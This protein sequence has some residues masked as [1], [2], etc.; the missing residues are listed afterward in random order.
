MQLVGSNAFERL[1][2]VTVFIRD[3]QKLDTSLK[4][5]DHSA[6]IGTFGDCRGASAARITGSF[7]MRVR[8]SCS[9]HFQF[10]GIAQS[11]VE[12]DS[13]NL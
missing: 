7:M 1:D 4:K 11:F 10:L 12:N 8:R 2:C 9:Y 6:G 13:Q 3:F 5:D